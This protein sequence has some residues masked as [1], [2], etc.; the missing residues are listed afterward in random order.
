MNIT[1]T[2]IFQMAFAAVVAT[3]VLAADAPLNSDKADPVRH[4]DPK[5]AEQL[6]SA[7]KV[8]VLDIR[9]PGEFKTGRIAGAKNLDFQAP[10]FEQR[11]KELDKSKSYLV[12]CAGGGRSSQSLTL[13]KKYH[14]E[15]I[16]H[17]DGGLKAWQKAGLPVEK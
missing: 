8:V 4:V 2:L 5:G 1:K 6:V 12:H 17:L 11:I 9:T 15:S 7:K 3:C 10:D 13:F 14:F 16:Y